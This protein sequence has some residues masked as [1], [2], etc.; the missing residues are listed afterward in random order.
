[1][2]RYVLIEV[3]PPE[4]VQK[5]VSEILKTYENL[6]GVKLVEAPISVVLIDPPRAIFRVRT[7]FLKFL[8]MAILLTRRVDDTDVLVVTIRVSGTLRKCKAQLKSIQKLM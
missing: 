4:L 6:L 2:A 5:V 1:M 8:R 3:Y 7:R